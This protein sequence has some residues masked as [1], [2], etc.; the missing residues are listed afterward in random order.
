MKFNSKKLI[1]LCLGVLMIAASAFVAISALVGENDKVAIAQIDVPALQ[2]GK[3]TGTEYGTAFPVLHL[4]EENGG[5]WAEDNSGNQFSGKLPSYVDVYLAHNGKS[6]FVGVKVQE[7]DHAKKVYDFDTFLGTNGDS[8]NSG[9]ITKFRMTDAAESKENGLPVDTFAHHATKYPE[10]ELWYDFQPY[11]LIDRVVDAGGKATDTTTQL[12]SKGKGGTFTYHLPHWAG[13]TMEA[14][15][16]FTVYEV[17]LDLAGATKEAYFSFDL[18]LFGDGTSRAGTLHCSIP[19]DSA[20]ASP[21]TLDLVNEPD[22]DSNNNILSSLT[23]ERGKL[24]PAFSADKTDYT[25]TLPEGVKDP[26][27]KAI[28]ASDKASVSIKGI[29]T[30]SEEKNIITVKVSAP[31]GAEKNYQI[32][33]VWDLVYTDFYVNTS[34]GS[35]SNTG[36][37]KDKAFRTLD[38][39]FDAIEAKAF[40]EFEGAKIHVTGTIEHKEGNILFGQKT[41]FNSANGKLPITL[42]AEGSATLNIT[43]AKVA[44]ANDYTFDGFANNF[45]TI[46]SNVEF[47]AG[48]GEITFRN[49]NLGTKSYV[50]YYADNFTQEA[51]IGWTAENRAAEE[52]LVYVYIDP[53]SERKAELEAKAKIK[54]IPTSITFG[55]GVTMTAGSSTKETSF[56]ASAGADATAYKTAEGALKIHPI[57][58]QTKIIINGAKLNAKVA[59]RLGNDSE[60]SHVFSTYITLNSGYV[61]MIAADTGDDDFGTVTRYGDVSVLMNGGNVVGQIGLKLL[62]SGTFYGD[63]TVEMHGGVVMEETNSAG[64]NSAIQFAS[65]ATV[66]GSTY[67]YVDES[68]STVYVQGTIGGGGSNYTYGEVINR[69]TAGSFG[70]FVGNHAGTSST[71]KNYI[72][73]GIFRSTNHDVRGTY[74]FSYGGGATGTSATGNVIPVQTIENH[75]SGGTF[76]GVVTMGNPV[77][78]PN[79]SGLKIKNYITGSPQFKTLTLEQNQSF[80]REALQYAVYNATT[81]QTMIDTSLAHANLKEITA[82]F[83]GGTYRSGSVQTVA[84]VT[85]YISGGTFDGEFYAG[86]KQVKNVFN[87]ISGG[88]FNGIYYGGASS[89]VTGNILN[90]ITANP[91]FGSK[92]YGGTNAANVA[93][94]ITNNVSGGTFKNETYGGSYTGTIGAVDGVSIENNISDI[95][96]NNVYYGGCGSSSA[97]ADLQA[98][99][100]RLAGSIQNSVT[101]GYF[102]YGFVGGHRRVNV[103]DCDVHT[104]FSGAT[105]G[106]DKNDGYLIFGCLFNSGKQSASLKASGAI[107]GEILSGTIKG[108]VA[109]L[110]NNIIDRT[111]NTGAGTFTADGSV[112]V[113]IKGGTIY[114]GIYPTA[115]DLDDSKILGKATITFDLTDATSAPTVLGTAKPVATNDSFKIT[116]GEGKLVLGANT[117]IAAA[118]ATGKVNVEQSS[119]WVLDQV[120]VTIAGDVKANVKAT[121]ADGVKGAPVVVVDGGNTKIQ[122]GLYQISAQLLIDSKISIRVLF[123]KGAV[124]A[125]NNFTYS[126]SANGINPISGDKNSLELKPINGKEY[127]VVLLPA[128]SVS[129][130]KDSFSFTA[131]E[132]YSSSFSIYSLAETAEGYWDQQGKTDWVAVAKAI[133]TLSDVYNDQAQNFNPEELGLVDEG[134]FV[135]NRGILADHVASFTASPIMNSGTAGLRFRLTLKDGAPMDALNVKIG[136]LD[137]PVTVEGNVVTVDI[138][139]NAIYAREKVNIRFYNGSEAFAT[140]NTSVAQIAYQSYQQNSGNV[141][142]N[143]AALLYFLQTVAVAGA[144]N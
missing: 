127:Y 10:T 17:E 6:L 66:Q 124:D 13:R 23:A 106:S 95:N 105:I 11:V 76:Y 34:S 28:A 139:F 18:G 128:L 82:Q 49:M 52:E 110:T 12:G 93:G 121:S 38:K 137:C 14:G 118:S 56:I 144:N 79:S 9:R 85:N 3:I 43:T 20:L 90:Q 35:D 103:L 99:T 83:H 107:S 132:H 142:N 47:Y 126:C 26:G 141:R 67:L 129:Q 62:R 143:A 78:G 114:G 100:N 130:F 109:G 29:D 60:A 40:S 27:L 81:V 75:I 53:A 133:Q 94:K 19:T 30:L 31:S 50:A 122:G 113:T 116:G 64:A 91:I 96:M 101:G 140:V 61:Y 71:I 46:S 57:D 32:K 125:I 36:E 16:D 2:D 74:D 59:G 70:S 41:I 73:G 111:Y 108:Y 92:Y 136:S 51:Y 87:Y 54:K 33:V 21:L 134:R 58:T 42:V 69:I 131:T 89:S 102:R 77:Y 104:S 88:N 72:S 119:D 15:T 8:K 138:Y 68:I 120:Y 44:C 117:N 84:E 22:P 65:G 135:V 86:G 98:G 4:T 55:D 1:A 37:S 48:S 97:V 25:L 112:N 45:N 24:E 80:V 39:A 115:N 5:F 7:E 63:I 123:E